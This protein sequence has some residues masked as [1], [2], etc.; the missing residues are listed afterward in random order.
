MSGL[1]AEE[2]KFYQ[3]KATFVLTYHQLM[4]RLESQR[5]VVERFD[6]QISEKE[7]LLS[8]I[9]EAIPMMKDCWKWDMVEYN[10]PDTHGKTES[11]KQN[12]KMMDKFHSLVNK[13]INNY[14]HAVALMK[15]S[16]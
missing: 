7:E 8:S 15:M 14:D 5:R 3:D 9:D 10:Y 6:P 2:K 11:I 12:L 16:S 4:S 13:Y 1:S